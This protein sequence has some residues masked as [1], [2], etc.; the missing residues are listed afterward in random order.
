MAVKRLRAGGAGK[1]QTPLRRIVGARRHPEHGFVEEVYECG[2]CGQPNSDVYGDTN[3]TR[4]RYWD[5]LRQT[6]PQIDQ[7]TLNKEYGT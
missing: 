1:S 3:E 4:R 6:A 5:C 2:H 7:R